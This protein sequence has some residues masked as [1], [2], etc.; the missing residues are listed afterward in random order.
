MIHSRLS[1][2]GIAAAMKNDT[3]AARK[4]SASV[5]PV[6]RARQCAS[7]SAATR[8]G[9]ARPMLIRPHGVS[10]ATLRSAHQQNRKC[11][12]AAETDSAAQKPGRAAFHISAKAPT[13]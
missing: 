6:M 10:V 7:R 2:S 8:N 12:S 11:A 9:T 3:P 1:S 5:A 13:A 4:P